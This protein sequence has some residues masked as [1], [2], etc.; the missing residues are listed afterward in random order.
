MGVDTEL[1]ALRNDLILVS[2][3]YETSTNIFILEMIDLRCQEN[4]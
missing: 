2:Q 3:S 1:N 4:V